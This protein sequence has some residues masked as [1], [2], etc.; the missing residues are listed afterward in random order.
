MGKLEISR[1]DRSPVR[2]L[3]GKSD[4]ADKSPAR[5]LAA[6]RERLQ[7]EVRALQRQLM[8]QRA[9]HAWVH[10]ASERRAHDDSMPGLPSWP[11]M[12]SQSATHQGQI[13]EPDHRSI[14]HGG[15]SRYLAPVPRP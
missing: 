5:G 8:A 7:R 2:G 13:Q 14:S 11:S 3:M 12:L 1:A 4:G 9:K 10:E 6:D 15:G